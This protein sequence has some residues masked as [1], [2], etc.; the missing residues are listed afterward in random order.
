MENTNIS[1]YIRTAHLVDLHLQSKLWLSQ[2]EFWKEELHFFRNLLGRHFIFLIEKNR[3]AETQ[4][5]ADKLSFLEDQEMDV[6]KKTILFHEQ[7]LAEILC[8]PSPE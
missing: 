1:D 7:N 5:L 8:F 4:V 6:L 2:I 3:R